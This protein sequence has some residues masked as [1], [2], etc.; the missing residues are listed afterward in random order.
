TECVRETR[1]NRQT[2]NLGK[3]RRRKD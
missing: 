3:T 1:G 2:G